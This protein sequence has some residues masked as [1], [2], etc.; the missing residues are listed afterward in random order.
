MRRWMFRKG[1]A[2]G[3]YGTVVQNAIYIATHLGYK[4]VHLYGVDHNFFDGLYMDDD[5]VLCS[6]VTHFY[7]AHPATKVQKSRRAT[8]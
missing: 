1:L 2:N 4:R 7:L 6:R 5:N 3:E 8:K